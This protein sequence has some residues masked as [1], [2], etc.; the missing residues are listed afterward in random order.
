MSDDPRELL[1]EAGV[2]CTE[3]DNVQKVVDILDG[4]GPMDDFA[5]EIQAASMMTHLNELR[6]DAI[7]ALARL[8]AKYKWQR[9][10]VVDIAEEYGG[11][12]FSDLDRRW[13]ERMN[14][15]DIGRI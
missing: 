15:D 7:L 1:K 4:F 12:D 3:V 2:E 11:C 13:E 9:D 10:Y 14:G 6:V 8:V 5:A